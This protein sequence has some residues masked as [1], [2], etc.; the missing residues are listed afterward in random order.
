MKVHVRI[1]GEDGHVRLP[2]TAVIQA[3]RALLTWL[4]T[5]TVDKPVQRM[6]D[7]ELDAFTLRPVEQRMGK[8]TAGGT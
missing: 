5:E 4:S 1:D 6:S 8:P 2:N 7:A 3:V